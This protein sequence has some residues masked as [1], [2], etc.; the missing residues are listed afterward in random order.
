MTGSSRSRRG[1]PAAC[2][3]QRSPSRAPSRLRPAKMET[4][5]RPSGAGPAPTRGRAVTVSAPAVTRQGR[6]QLL[7]IAAASIVLFVLTYAFTV[8]TASGQKLDIS[9]LK[10]RHVLSRHDLHVAQRLHTSLDLAS[11]ALL[12][13]AILLVALLRGRP[14]VAVGVFALIV[15]SLLTSE[16]L[17]QVLGR[18]N[19]GVAGAFA[20]GASFP[21]GHTTIAMALA[22]GA[23]FV[24]PSRFRVAVAV[25]GVVF[26]ST[27]GCSLVATASHRP[28]DVVGAVLVV[29]AWAAVIAAMLLR[30]DARGP[31]RRA[32]LL[33]ASP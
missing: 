9:A 32:A 3:A 25:L 28:G 22:V 18:P 8:R 23:V 24:S 19:L 5:G 7:A 31:R 11:L 14:R 6:G 33:R 2:H 4:D 26:A 27:I 1:R 16:T 29:T 17:K 13:S 15:G 10:G 20:K 21:S 30:P 12:G